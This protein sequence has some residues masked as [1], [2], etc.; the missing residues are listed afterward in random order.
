MDDKL[1][2]DG[3][4]GGVNVTPEPAESELTVPPIASEEG[5]E[6]VKGASELGQRDQRSLANSVLLVLTVTFAMIVNVRNSFFFE[7]FV[8]F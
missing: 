6:F 7:F 3:G 8:S 5:E 4:G 1:L 2:R